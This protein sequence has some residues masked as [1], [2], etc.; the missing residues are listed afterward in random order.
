MTSLRALLAT[1]AVATLAASAASAQVVIV[2]AKSDIFLAGQSTV[3]TDFP[4]NPGAPGLGAGLLPPSLVVTAG[5]TLDIT[6]SGLVSCCLGGSPT[7]GPNG[8]GLGGTASISGYGDVG[9]YTGVEFPLVGVF[10]GP[11]LTPPWTVFVIG[12]FDKV[13]VPV[14]A[15]ELYLGLPDSLGFGQQPGYYNDN[16]GAFTVDIAVPEP[17]SWALML[18]GFV[19]LGAALRRRRGLA[20]A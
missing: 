9:G 15:T 13:V 17:A 14:G 10:G 6:A 8:G 18:T 4:F 3:P 12:S 16:T 7:N 11:S 2:D 19:G 20:T 5:E 1:A